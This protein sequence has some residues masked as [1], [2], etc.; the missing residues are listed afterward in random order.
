MHEKFLA[1]LKKR[2]ADPAEHE[3]MSVMMKEIYRAPELLKRQSENSKKY[4][5]EHPYTPEQRAQISASVKKYHAEHPES[6]ETRAKKTAALKRRW[7]KIHAVRDFFVALLVARREVENSPV[8]VTLF[9]GETLK[10]FSAV[11]DIFRK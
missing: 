3:R 6:V 9:I 8:F 5:A 2:W 7:A 10:K 11:A 1:M 4:R